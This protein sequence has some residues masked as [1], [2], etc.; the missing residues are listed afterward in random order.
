[1]SSNCITDTA[2][3]ICREK[4]VTPMNVRI[5]LLKSQEKSNVGP[6]SDQIFTVLMLSK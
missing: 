3:M 5:L 2:S 4:V 6:P 1:M